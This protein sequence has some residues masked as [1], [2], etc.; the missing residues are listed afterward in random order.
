MLIWFALILWAVFASGF[1]AA[2]VHFVTQ[3]RHSQQIR[4]YRDILRDRGVDVSGQ[5]EATIKQTLKEVH[6]RESGGSKVGSVR[7]V[8]DFGRSTLARPKSRPAWET[9]RSTEHVGGH[10]RESL[11]PPDVTRKP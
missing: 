11:V 6:L 9:D 3:K 1:A 2:A 5:D 7:P 4:A 10:T 8:P